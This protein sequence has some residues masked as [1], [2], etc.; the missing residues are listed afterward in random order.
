MIVAIDKRDLG[1]GAD[2]A[3]QVAKEHQAGLL[4]KVCFELADDRLAEQVGGEGE[5]AT[6]DPDD[7]PDGFGRGGA[8]D[9]FFGP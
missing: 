9:R 5:T 6:A 2:R 1:R 4:V 8:G 3:F 7:R